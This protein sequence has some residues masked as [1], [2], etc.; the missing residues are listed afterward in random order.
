MSLFAWLNVPFTWSKGKNNDKW[1]LKKHVQDMNFYLSFKLS[2]FLFSFVLKGIGIV[3][4]Q[5]LVMSELLGTFSLFE[6][7]VLL[8]FCIVTSAQT[9]LFH[10][11][12]SCTTR[13]IYSPL[14]ISV[15]VLLF[16]AAR[17]LIQVLNYFLLQNSYSLSW[18]PA[19][20]KPS[21]ILALYCFEVLS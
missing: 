17:S 14:K 20:T 11:S 19:V 16:P 10:C 8:E 6:L 9:Q 13:G 1:V 2:Y 7:L 18:K 15:A 5:G 12:S 21:S 3:L 4:I